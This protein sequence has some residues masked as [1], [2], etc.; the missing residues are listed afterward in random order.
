MAYVP[1]EEGDLAADFLVKIN[2]GLTKV[3]TAVSSDEG[4]LLTK[5]TDELPHLPPSAVLAELAD[6]KA[7]VIA[8]FRNGVT[9]DVTGSLTSAAHSGRILITSGNVVIP[10]AAD[11]VGFNA[12]LIAGGAHTVTF[13]STVSAAMA[14]GDLMTL[15]VQSTTVIQA[16]LTAAANKVAFT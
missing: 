9:A 2:D 11:D 1:I 7:S 12:V 5:G 8:N 14:E 16:V 15:F 13:N 10:N 4:N 6:C 3:D